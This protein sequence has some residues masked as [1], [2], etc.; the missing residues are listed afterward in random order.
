[1]SSYQLQTI[2][3]TWPFSTWRLDLVGLFK[4]AKGGFTWPPKL[5]ELHHQ[6]TSSRIGCHLSPSPHLPSCRDTIWLPTTSV[7]LPPPPNAAVPRW[8]PPPLRHC[9]ALASPLPR[10]HVRCVPRGLHTLTPPASASLTHATARAR[11][12]VTSPEAHLAVPCGVGRSGCFGHWASLAV[13]DLGLFWAQYCVPV[14]K[15]FGIKLNPKKHMQ[16]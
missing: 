9:I 10:L 2:P 1:V 11:R 4:R 16:T 13:L 12:T 3:I 7:W 14:L 6:Q 5:G 15:S 8:V